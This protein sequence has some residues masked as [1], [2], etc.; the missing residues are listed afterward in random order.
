MLCRKA[1]LSGTKENGKSHGKA[2]GMCHWVTPHIPFSPANLG[3]HYGKRGRQCPSQVMSC[4]LPQTSNFNLPKQELASRPSYLK[5]TEES[6]FHQHPKLPTL[7]GMP[8][9]SQVPSVPAESSSLIQHGALWS[10]S[11]SR[12]LWYIYEGLNWFCELV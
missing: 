9:G 7:A 1:S 10:K 8:Y 5:A 6:V 2:D 12:P 4:W 3:A 11:Q